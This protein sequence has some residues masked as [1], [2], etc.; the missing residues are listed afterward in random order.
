MAGE[1]CGPGCGYCGRCDADYD[2]PRYGICVT[3][4]EYTDSRDTSYCWSCLETR[5]HI[6]QTRDK[7]KQKEQAAK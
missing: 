2:A 3:C 4:G 5:D 7:L 6:R 1:L